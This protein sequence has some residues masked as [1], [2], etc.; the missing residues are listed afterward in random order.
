MHNNSLLDLSRLN[1][2]LDRRRVILFWPLFHE[3]V[4]KMLFKEFFHPRCDETPSFPAF[5]RVVHKTAVFDVENFFVARMKQNIFLQPV[6]AVAG[7]LFEILHGPPNFVHVTP[8]FQT[9]R[10]S[11]ITQ[12]EQIY[13]YFTLVLTQQTRGSLGQIQIMCKIPLPVQ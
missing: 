7:P 4:A 2:H 8:S 3:Y 12:S 9:V 1:C 5:F 10:S 6:L 13:I 11:N